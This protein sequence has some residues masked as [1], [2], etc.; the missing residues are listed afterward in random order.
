MEQE[1]EYIY[2]IQKA[3]SFSKA[4]ENLH[5]TQPAL[6]MAVKRIEASIGMTLFDR[7]ARPLELTEAGRIYIDSIRKILAVE[8]DLNNRIRDIDELKSGHL[9]IGGSH[10]INAYILPEVMTN[11]SA[12]YPGINLEL[13]EASSAELAGMLSE[14]LIDLT[15]TCR[16][17]IIANFEHFPTFSDHIILA[18]SP[19]I[20]NL[21][22]A[23]SAND[24]LNGKHLNEDCPTIPASAMNELEYIIL[25]EGN[26]LHDR[27][28]NIF[29]DMGIKPEIKIEISQLATSY[30][31]ARANFGA[32]FVSDKMIK[33]DENK[34]N[35]Y[36]INSNE[37]DRFFYA[38]L[39]QR[40]Y[41][42]KAV[43]AFIDEFTTRL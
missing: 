35:F 17:D 15:L 12:K 29:R 25:S 3:G 20:L 9:R 34:L 21:D 27:A 39:P 10:F 13:V 4:A 42:P 6:S 24:I 1:L 8:E 5:V 33:A 41:T 14:R 2:E 28:K 26:N 32:A 36:R 38:V 23:L 31:L 19:E 22:C 18:V 37:C 40:E 7:T 16:A 11:Y 43:R 30:Y